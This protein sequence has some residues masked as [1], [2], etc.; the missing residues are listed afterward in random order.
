MAY[1]RVQATRQLTGGARVGIKPPPPIVM[2]PNLG[3]ESKAGD[4]SSK[5]TA[6]VEKA[7]DRIG[8]EKETQSAKEDDGKV[9]VKVLRYG[10]LKGSHTVNY[11]AVDKEAKRGEDYTLTDGQLTFKDGESEKTIAVGMIEDGV[12]EEDETFEIVL[13]KAQPPIQLT[14]DKLTF[15]IINIDF[16]GIIC[17]S[18]QS[19]SVCESEGKVIVQVERIE[20]IAGTVSCDYRCKD[21]TALA[22]SDYIAKEGTLTFGPGEVKK[23]I[24]IEII[25]D[26]CYE[27][28]E[29]FQACMR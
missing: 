11:R 10:T 27:K 14:P 24:E 3:A 17:F 6:V 13:E 2:Q 9:L 21:E 22:V 12:F 19:Y 23:T 26:G 29:T 1:Y 5:E 7:A 28:D 25:D 8:F 18:E 16:P 20:G 15:T 4:P